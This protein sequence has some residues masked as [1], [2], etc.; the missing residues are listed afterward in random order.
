MFR[1]LARRPGGRLGAWMDR[2]MTNQSVERASLALDE[3]KRFERE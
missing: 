3:I 1:R 2:L